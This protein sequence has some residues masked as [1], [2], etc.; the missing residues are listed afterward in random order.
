MLRIN[1]DHELTLCLIEYIIED[2]YSLSDF[3]E[4][5]DSNILNDFFDDN[6]YLEY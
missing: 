6:F 4:A 5:S 1:I 2:M 3:Y